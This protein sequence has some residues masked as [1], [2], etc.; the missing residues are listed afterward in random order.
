MTVLAKLDADQAR[1]MT[2]EVKADAESLWTK[3]LALY[4]A[5]V[6]VVLGY[7]S[8]GAYYE[9]EFGQSGRRGYQL[10]AAGKAVALLEEQNDRDNAESASET[11]FTGRR[12]LPVARPRDTT[13]GNGRIPLPT[14]EAT[15]R[16]LAATMKNDPERGHALWGESVV[17]F[18]PGATPE[19]VQQVADGIGPTEGPRGLDDDAKRF[20][21]AARRALKADDVQ[22][23]R[24]ALAIWRASVYPGLDRIA[25]GVPR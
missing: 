16:K 11:D 7:G 8:W 15:A 2:D 4:E 1:A 22:A 3:I 20:L 10:L 17:R 18:G 24:Q 9:A 13:S 6:H 5:G 21:S 12:S 14:N 23:A 25:K 19:Q